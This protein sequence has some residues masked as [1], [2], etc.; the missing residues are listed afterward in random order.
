[1]TYGVGCCITG[2]YAGKIKQHPDGLKEF[3]GENT[4]VT[5]EAI[6]AVA[7]WLYENHKEYNFTTRDGRRLILKIEGE[8]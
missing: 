5:K 2:I 7:Q 4:D 6:G 1:M 3:V 8:K